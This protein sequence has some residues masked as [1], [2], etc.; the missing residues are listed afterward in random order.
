MNKALKGVL[1]ALAVV[2]A[3]TIGGFVAFKLA[4]TQIMNRYMLL[5]KTDEEYF[6]W[7]AG[8]GI[9]LAADTIENAKYE[10]GGFVSMTGQELIASKPTR[11]GFTINYGS[12]SLFDI[13]MYLNR[14]AKEIYFEAPMLVD[15]AVSIGESV[16]ELLPEDVQSEIPVTELPSDEKIREALPDVAE[17]IR[18]Y[19]YFILDQ[20]HQVKIDKDCKEYVGE[21]LVTYN[22][23]TVTLPG[24]D[25]RAIS[26]GMLA[27]LQHD[28]DIDELWELS[29]IDEIDDATVRVAFCVLNNMIPTGINVEVEYNA[30]KV[31][32]DA[33]FVFDENGYEGKEAVTLNGLEIL[34]GTVSMDK[35]T[36]GEHSEASLKLGSFVAQLAGLKKDVVINVTADSGER[37]WGELRKKEACEI[38][39]VLTEGRTSLNRL[40]GYAFHVVDTLD[41]QYVND[42]LDSTLP[43]LTGGLDMAAV[44]RLYD[45]GM[46]NTVTADPE[47][48][49]KDEPE[50]EPTPEPTPVPTAIPVPTATPVPTEAPDQSS[51]AGDAA[52]E[53]TEDGEQNSI[54]A[55]LAELSP[56]EIEFRKMIYLSQFDRMIRWDPDE[57]E[58]EDKDEVTIDIV[59]VLYGMLM[60]NMGYYDCAAYIGEDTYGEG[61][62]AELMGMR[63]GDYKDITT[64]IG[65][66]VPMLSDYAGMTVTVRVTV[67]DIARYIE[68]EWTK[69]FFSYVGLYFD[70][71]D[72]DSL[73]LLV[74]GWE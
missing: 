18:N 23:I 69:E 55:A 32:M 46:F 53:G 71:F 9:D 8:K 30:T 11:S 20:V 50:P 43:S 19:G 64:T 44:R 59:P 45:M 5:T 28:I 58:I 1:I 52:E 7:L 15:G 21:Q 2:A 41:N 54:E 14:T 16:K 3:L 12:E 17:K 38:E 39:N 35:K 49:V 57:L 60:E 24:K 51:D 27:Y 66:D 31:A 62:D 10:N 36:E 26:E 22:K 48:D 65:E 72:K 56:E 73:A 4:G 74:E 47:S 68:P 6:K 67:K 61:T 34:S 63:V 42:F 40:I 25:L 70:D 33:L 13:S 29:V 37:A